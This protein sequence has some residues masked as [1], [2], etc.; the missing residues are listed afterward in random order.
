MP[1]YN[2]TEYGTEPLQ[3]AIDQTREEEYA[4]QEAER[5]RREEEQRQEQER[6]R[7]ALYA[8]VHPPDEVARQQTRDAIAYNATLPTQQQYR[9]EQQM[10][11]SDRASGF[12]PVTYGMPSNRS[13]GL[14]DVTGNATINPP[15][16]IV[17]TPGPS[18]I[19][20]ARQRAIDSLGGGLDF[21]GKPLGQA[22][23]YVGGQPITPPRFLQ[24]AV[25]TITP[26]GTG[27]LPQ[28]GEPGYAPTTVGGFAKGIASNV[29]RPTIE[30]SQIPGHN[31]PIIG[32]PVAEAISALTSPGGAITGGAFGA[33]I[34]AKMA[35]GSVGG[36]VLGQGV[37]AAGIDELPVV[38]SPSKF[39]QF[40][41]AFAGPAVIDR[42]GAA[43]GEAASRRI[44]EPL[45]EVGGRTITSAAPTAEE[46]GAVAP[47]LAGGAQTPEELRAAKNA[48][49]DQLDFADKARL[50]R[51]GIDA[52]AI[53]Q[54]EVYAKLPEDIKA[55]VTPPPGMQREP[56]K[57]G[58]LHAL[59]GGEDPTPGLTPSDRALNALKRTVGAGTEEHPLVAGI[60]RSR[61][62]LQRHGESL[63][64]R[65]GSVASKVQRAFKVD[66]AGRILTLEGTPTIQDVAANLPKYEAALTPEQRSVLTSFRDE[67]APY[68]TALEEQG[69]EFGSRPDIV[70]GGF[71]LPRGRANLEGAEEP[72]KVGA[73]R[74][75][76]GGKKGFERAAQFDAMA[77]G[78]AAGYRY[79]PF[80]EA[81]Q[82]YAKD[83][84]TRVI[85]A[86]A[87]GLLG[88]ATDEAG[89]L[90]GKTAHARLLEQN[91]P[92]AEKV[93]GIRNSVQR[94]RN[95]LQ[96]LT[97]RQ[98]EVLDRFAASPG[99]DLD[100]LDA[101]LREIRARPIRAGR[102]NLT[103]P[104]VLKAYQ[105]A[106]KD[107]SEVL[108]EWRKALDRARQ[109]PR[110]EGQIGFSA[111]QGT[112]FPD[113]IANAANKYLQAERALSGRGALPQHVLGA[114]NNLLRGVRA[115]AD[116]S[117][118]G[119][120]GLLGAVDHP[121]S[122]GRA[123]KTALRS[124]GDKDAIGAHIIQF[125]EKAAARGAPTSAE[126]AKA[127]IHIGGPD[128][129]FAVTGKGLGGKL[130]QIQNLPIAKQSNRAFGTFG[131]TL[132]LEAAD[133]MW[134][135]GMT[136]AELEE[137]A[138]A[139]N[140]MTGWSKGK[141]LGDTG[142]LVEFAPRFFQSQLELVANA[143]T[144]G[145]IEGTAARR[146][147]LKLIGIGTL[148]TA[149]LN[150]ALPGG[151]P[152]REYLDPRSNNFMRVR[153]GGQDISFFGPW[154][155]LLK[156]VVATAKGDPTYLARTKASPVVQ[157]ATDYI[158][159]KNFLGQTTRHG[160]IPDPEA[161]LR[162][163]L[164][165]SISDIGQK[166]PLGS[167]IGVTGVKA[168]DVTKAEQRDV[169]RDE[170]ANRLYGKDYAEL[171]QT[172]QAAVNAD[173]QVA[174][175]IAARKGQAVEAGDEYGQSLT[176]DAAFQQALADFQ[177]TGKWKGKVVMP[178]GIA[179]IDQN[180]LDG[181]TELKDWLDA[182][183]TYQDQVRLARAERT[184]E[185]TPF[186]GEP[187][188]NPIDAAIDAV[189]AITPSD[190]KYYDKLTN[191]VDWD[192]YFADKK[193]ATDAAIKAGALPDYFEK[194]EDRPV[195]ALQDTA[196]KLY[197]DA[198]AKYK[199]MS[200]ED[201]EVIDKEI[202]QVV[203][204][205]QVLEDKLGY[206]VTQKNIATV[207]GD[208]K[209][210]PD[211]LYNWQLLS[212][213]TKRS[214]LVTPA[215]DAYLTEHRPELERFY[216][217]LFDKSYLTRIGDY[218]AESPFGRPSR[219]T[220]PE[221][222]SR[223]TREDIGEQ[224]AIRPLLPELL[225]ATP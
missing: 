8:M 64:N 6:Q 46:F 133:A 122:Y 203:E 3:L 129:E 58:L 137:V 17:A 143:L 127:G 98:S 24:T 173:P 19:E 74:G 117:F 119:I 156:G 5:K 44:V 52:Q 12:G 221:R 205:Q 7:A 174:A 202:K 21:I 37:E 50:Q 70:D 163:L 151:I 160:F 91:A 212:S 216:S 194:V 4:R 131:D 45:E 10:A 125:D 93:A 49:Q 106:R 39:G 182:D 83:A 153:V 35:A 116:V 42:A 195:K 38:G 201:E 41:G 124:L 11:Y 197:D 107:L 32:R 31:I 166:G 159:G 178:Q 89:A 192:T 130:E 76:A 112:S 109:T 78:I 59:L 209:N 193:A 1:L 188:T 128:T 97:K 79:A 26:G 196:R 155:S 80:P 73:G 126:W 47:T 187:T 148:A 169:S 55:K 218:S 121:I 170:A 146:Q 75:G 104:E 108:P 29:F 219:P 179:A 165:F 150:E 185:K 224:D 213:P 175:D 20:Y 217:W 147:L 139:S 168:S 77:D 56:E 176:G 200:R 33:G 18:P 63:A 210:D 199:G 13:T 177:A 86:H 167:L 66:K 62:D 111:L 135:P 154:D 113:A 171:D 157:L 204:L 15:T 81:V 162:G 69:I 100:E 53:D 115:T 51:L 183:H 190:P 110:T 180:F 220:R 43:I 16:P 141:F 36:D 88:T 65:L 144:K 186:S 94:L 114:V 132:R 207:L 223:P 82:S 22:I 134:R 84:A 95:N 57:N 2:T 99:P 85:D 87:A 30:A 54:P 118:M 145:G 138:N 68:R 123:L 191:I 101:T 25:R 211:L 102:G 120:Q 140:L 206:P 90:I 40:A 164:P 34:T 23:N 28:E 67:F 136:A 181:K 14:M 149:G 198:P 103:R 96:S 60:M 61:Q 9:Q 71:Y 72:L 208:Y 92:L 152:A 158:S 225:G 161:F 184:S 189:F 222:P 142:N 105:Q 48:I 215:Y 214:A 27:G 172:R